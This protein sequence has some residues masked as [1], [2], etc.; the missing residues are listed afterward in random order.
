MSEINSTPA[1]T[2]NNNT[3]APTPTPS[4]SPTSDWTSSLN[5]EHKGWVQSKGFKDMSGVVESY[6]NS[7][8]LISKLKGAN[9][10]R[11][12]ALPE[13]ADDPAWND[14]YGRLGKP[15]K[16]D[17]YKISMPE[18][19]GNEDFAKWARETFHGLNLTS[20]QAEKLSSKWNEYVGTSTK[21]QEDA[22]KVEIQQQTESLKKE[23]GAAFEQNIT[24][25]DMA[26]EKLGLDENSLVKMKEVFGAAGAAKFLHSLGAK[27]GED[28]LV[29]PQQGGGAFHI[30]TPASAQSR[31]NALR[32]DKDFTRRLLNGDVMA[33]QEWD[34]LNKQAAAGMM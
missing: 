25:M 19:G 23:W 2:L 7:E 15:Q 34:T 13:K 21:A 10:D 6:R 8:S 24:I 14:V 1:P 18:K 29:T 12:I 33:K 17:E 11:V 20:S 5:D 27:M 31:I 16:P 32:T 9:S 3:P 30:H 28:P 22:A 26:A 4:P